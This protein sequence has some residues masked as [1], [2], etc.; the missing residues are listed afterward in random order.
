MADWQIGRHGGDMVTLP[1][2]YQPTHELVNV[3]GTLVSLAGAQTQQTVAQKYSI[4]WTWTQLDDDQ[5]AA[6]A[7]WHRQEHGRGPFDVIDPAI[8]PDRIV[9]NIQS[10]TPNSGPH[11][12]LWAPSMVMNQ[13]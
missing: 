13:V 1:K 8:G 2:C 4:T 5:Y 12:G 10:L 3:G 6:V 9:V 11:L 7:G